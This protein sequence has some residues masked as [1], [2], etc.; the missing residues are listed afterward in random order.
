MNER[1]DT[2]FGRGTGPLPEST[3]K[4]IGAQSSKDAHCA[5]REMLKSGKF[6]I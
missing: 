2:R 5:H 3:L 1:I 4:R 6:D